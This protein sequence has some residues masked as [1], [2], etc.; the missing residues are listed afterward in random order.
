MEHI[1]GLG[2]IA[3]ARP[4]WLEAHKPAQQDHIHYTVH[5]KYLYQTLPDKHDGRHFQL[6]IPSSLYRHYLQYARDNP[7][8][9]HL[10][11]IKTLQ[12]LL[13][14]VYWPSIHPDVWDLCKQWLVTQKL[15]TAYHPQTSLTEQINRYLKSM[16]VS[17]VH[18]NHIGTDG[19]QSS[20]LPSTRCGMKQRDLLQQK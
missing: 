20:V 11:S 1:G 8:S 17:Y 5:N 14:M 13:E 4:L 15:T 16:I 9:G 12:Q 18:T 6:V 7:F 10:G 19:Y 2:E 3:P